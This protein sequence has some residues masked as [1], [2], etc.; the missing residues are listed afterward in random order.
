V[1]NLQYSSMRNAAYEMKSKR[2][3]WAGMWVNMDGTETSGGG[4]LLENGH[5]KDWGD[6]R[7]TS[8]G[9]L[10]CSVF[11][12]VGHICNILLTSI[13]QYDYYLIII[14]KHGGITL[15]QLL[16]KETDALNINIDLY[17][18]MKYLYLLQKLQ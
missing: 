7:I 16:C 4:N 8:N 10:V 14:N 15:N 13:T 11:L 5:L 3:W 2:L 9:S 17:L 6:W 18:K 12:Q 1:S